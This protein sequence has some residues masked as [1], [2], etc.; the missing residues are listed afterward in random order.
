M[1]ADA[2]AQANVPAA[3][4]QSVTALAASLARWVAAALVLSL[5]LVTGIVLWRWAAGALRQPLG[6]GLL[7]AAAAMAFLLI[8]AARLAWPVDGRG[9][10]RGVAA[11]AAAW[12]G[13]VAGAVVAVTLSLP[14]TALAGLLLVWALF[15]AEEWFFWGMVYR[16]RAKTEGLDVAA[17][18]SAPTEEAEP[19]AEPPAPVEAEPTD[20]PAGDVLQQFTRSVTPEGAERMVGWVRVLF[21]P[22]Q[23]NA[24]VH[25]AF[26]P[27]FVRTPRVSVRQL[28]GPTARVRVAQLLPFGV[29]MDLKLTIQMAAPLEVLLQFTAQ[30]DPPRSAPSST[31]SGG[32]G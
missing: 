11:W 25:V 3:P 15:A 21:A 9:Q 17:A 23:R 28:E 20:P 5:A 27:P 7:A 24:T 26:C 12:P 13:S 14:G 31:T 10:C 18:V 29:R 1:N 6:F 2:V 4:G 8:A 19:L 16:R 30:T 22:N 32:A